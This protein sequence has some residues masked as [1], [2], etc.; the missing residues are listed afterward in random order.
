MFSWYGVVI[1]LT[2]YV[3]TFN[4]SRENFLIIYLLVGQFIDMPY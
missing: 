3:S 4:L 2:G 1:K